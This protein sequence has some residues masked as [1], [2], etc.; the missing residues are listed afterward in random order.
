MGDEPRDNLQRMFADRQR[1]ERARRHV[2]EV[3]RAAGP[4]AVIAL[5]LDRSA[6][7]RRRGVREKR[8]LVW[9]LHAL[10]RSAIP[11]TATFLDSGSR[12]EG[13]IVLAGPD[14]GLAAHLAGRLRALVA[15][16]DFELQDGT[17]VRLT[18][19]L[20]IVR[21]PLH[22]TTGAGLLWAAGEAMW[23]AKRTRDAV[24]EPSGPI[25][26]TRKEFPVTAGQR[27]RLAVLARHTGRPVS[28]LFHEAMELLLENHAPR[29]HWIV[30]MGG[31]TAGDGG[32]AAEAAETAETGEAE[33]ASDGRVAGAAQ[34]APAEFG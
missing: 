20:G 12:D 5:D 27:E 23:H 4:V 33:A 7:V 30:E 21:S 3:L 14:A 31:P 17:A 24:H 34:A 16:H 11:G 2:D 25:P 8:A 29:W 22:G 13:W 19:S 6:V 9:Q 32:E 26:V 15:S 10:I 18:A 1:V 28:S